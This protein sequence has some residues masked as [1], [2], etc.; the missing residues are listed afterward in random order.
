MYKC[1]VLLD[2][3]TMGICPKQS[4]FDHASL[5]NE[6]SSNFE[7]EL[8]EIDKKFNEAKGGKLKYN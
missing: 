5:S 4:P 3:V 6:E 7:K 2:P 1:T 8:D